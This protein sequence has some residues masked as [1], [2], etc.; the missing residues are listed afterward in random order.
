[1][2]RQVPKQQAFGP[3]RLF[4]GVK[5]KVHRLIG[6][7]ST[8]GNRRIPVVATQPIASEAPLAVVE[9]IGHLKVAKTRHHRW[10][11]AVRRNNIYW[12]TLF[13][14]KSKG[15]V[16]PKRRGKELKRGAHEPHNA[17]HRCRVQSPR[18]IC[19]PQGGWSFGEWLH[20]CERANAF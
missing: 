10:Q 13:L 7:N 14:A 12:R 8:T 20:N 18:R 5:T 19:L 11:R 2:A 6:R 15:L 17:P 4:I 9:S 1:M 16:K 3:M